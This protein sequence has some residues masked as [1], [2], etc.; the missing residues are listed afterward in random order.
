MPY[1]LCVNAI[2]YHHGPLGITNQSPRLGVASPFFLWRID[3]K[4]NPVVTKNLVVGRI[5]PIEDDQR[6]F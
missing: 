6:G 5:L 2:G 4:P 1:D 3:T